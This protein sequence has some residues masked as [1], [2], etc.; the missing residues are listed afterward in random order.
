MSPRVPTC[1]FV[2]AGLVFLA[3]GAAVSLLPS[4]YAIDIFVRDEYFV[5]PIAHAAWFAASLCGV[6][7]LLRGLIGRACGTT[8]NS[9]C[10][11]L[12]FWFS[13][14]GLC[15]I[16]GSMF[17]A[18]LR[19]QQGDSSTMTTLFSFALGGVLAFAAGQLILACTAI[20]GLLRVFRRAMT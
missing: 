13:V 1:R 10:E 15:T 16:V 17:L 14:G 6:L 3:A 5:L 2:L 7:A 18:A 4:D 11:K 8:H 12:H 20:Y 9:V 19:A